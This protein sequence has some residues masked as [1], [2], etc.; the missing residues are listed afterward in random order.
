MTPRIIIGLG[1]PG[2]QYANTYHNVGF[3]FIDYLKNALTNYELP[4][5]NY[6]LLKSD[7]YMNESGNFVAKTLRKTDA[8]PHDLCIAHDDSDIPLGSFKI[9]FG[10][11]SAGHHGIENIIRA[12]GTKNFTR[13]R[14]GIR[15]LAQIPADGKLINADRIKANEFV[16]KKITRTNQKILNRVFQEAAET[17]VRNL[18]PSA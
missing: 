11:G 6:Q 2:T 14:I 15:P 10:R 16:L 9:S 13:L 1:N 12:I 4:I 5:T 7:V 3:L 8:A 18:R 17:L